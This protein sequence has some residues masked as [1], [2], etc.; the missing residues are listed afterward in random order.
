MNSPQTPKYAAVP[1]EPRHPTWLAAGL[2]SVWIVVL[3]LPLNDSTRALIDA[4]ALAKM[5]PG[6]L[7]VNVA[8]GPLVVEDDLVAALQS[9]RLAGA[10]MDVTATEPLSPKS[11]LWDCP[12]VIITPHVAGQSARRIDNMT[13]LFCANI[14]RWK[15]GEPLINRLTDR[16]LGFPIRGVGVPLWSE[17]DLSRV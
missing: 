9:G 16:Q 11:R 10:V 5:N 2:C 3:S 15:A 13:R 4:A 1:F 6:A 7:L 12:S 17:V 14:R 8:R